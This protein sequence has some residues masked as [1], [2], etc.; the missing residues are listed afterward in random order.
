MPFDSASI[1]RF[2]PGGSYTQDFVADGDRLLRA[3]AAADALSGA[4]D[5]FSDDAEGGAGAHPGWS[6]LGGPGRGQG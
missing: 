1:L 6:D 5:A 4:G 3:E 2:G